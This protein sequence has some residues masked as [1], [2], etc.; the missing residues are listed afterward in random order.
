M[1]NKD[2]EYGKYALADPTAN[3]YTR[4]VNTSKYD[5]VDLSSS[6]F[7]QWDKTTAGAASQASTTVAFDVGNNTDIGSAGTVVG[8]GEVWYHTYADMTGCKKL[9]IEGTPGMYLRVSLNRQ[10]PIDPSEQ[11]YDS[12]GGSLVQRYCLLDDNGRG[13][14]DVSDLPYVHINAIKNW[15]GSAGKVNSVSVLRPKLETVSLADSQFLNYSNNPPSTPNGIDFHVNDGQTVNPWGTVAGDGNVYYLT[16][17]DLSGSKKLVIRGTSGMIL[18]VLMN[19]QSDGGPLVERV[20]TIG[21]NGY[22]EVDLSDLSY[23][24]LNCV[25]VR[26]GSPSGTIT[27]INLINLATTGDSR[28]L[29]HDQGDGWQVPQWTNQYTD[30]WHAAFYPV[31]VP[32][33]G[34]DEFFQVLVGLTGSIGSH[35][36]IELNG[37]S[38]SGVTVSENDDNNGDGHIYGGTFTPTEG[39]RNIFK[40]TDYN[41]HSYQKIVI[42]FGSEVPE[43][44]HLQTY[45]PSGS[46]EGTVPL[47]GLMEYEVELRPGTNMTDFSIF[48]DYRTNNPITIT[49]MYFTSSNQ[50]TEM[51]RYDGWADPYS[52]IED[53][54]I[55]W[56][57]EQ[58]DDYAHYR[59]KNPNNG[60]YLS[61]V[62]MVT[63]PNDP[64]GEVG[65]NKAEIY[66]NQKFWGEFYLKWFLPTK[67]VEKEIPVNGYVRHRESYLKAYADD[68]VITDQ[69]GLRKQG[70]ARDVDSDWKELTNKKTG[71]PYLL[72][73]FIQQT[74]Y[75]EIT[76][77]IKKG[78]SKVIEFPTVLNRNNDHIFFQRFYIR[79]N[80]FVVFLFLIGKF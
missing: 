28:Y 14:V 58:E 29:H 45:G 71:N 63:E 1:G 13:E 66:T 48:N 52:E 54:R 73:G 37:T 38:D 8:T 34:K 56:Q 47:N 60:T 2:L 44:Y 32:V 64:N 49:E 55:L 76:H 16:Y 46:M 18:R 67:S 35:H 80:S 15:G 19:R 59:L 27:E 23:V 33:S 79:F 78:A 12:H 5:Y 39:Y 51:V 31:E 50:P 11:G 70:L 77:Y 10:V 43:G 74:N 24:H 42:K 3:R 75:F 68:Q 26:D 4:I 17:A 7:Y 72:D 65:T 20:T 62:G 21:S 9:V 41:T 30:I 22:A 6:H 40:Y 36:R 61:G 25:K 69:D 53:E 57:L